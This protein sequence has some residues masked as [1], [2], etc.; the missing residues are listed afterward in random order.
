MKFKQQQSK[1]ESYMSF[2]EFGAEPSKDAPVRRVEPL[3]VVPWPGWRETHTES[4]QKND[5]GPALV[6][7]RLG[8][9]CTLRLSSQTSPH[10][11]GTDRIPGQYEGGFKVWSCSWD[12][13]SWLYEDSSLCAGKVVLEIGCG[14]AVPSIVSGARSL[15]LQDFNTEVLTEAVIPNLLANFE[16][17]RMRPE[18]V[19]LLSCDWSQLVEY[20]RSNNNVTP[21][22]VLGTDVTFTVAACRD[23]AAV[24]STIFTTNA[25]AVAF[26]ATKKYYFGT[27][28]GVQ[29]FTSAC[30]QCLGSIILLETVWSAPD[31]SRSILRV[32][33]RGE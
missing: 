31:R 20:L 19:T 25:K 23:V 9:Q 11:A 5:D 4:S 16:S 24:L 28:G 29:E 22:V 18:S 8:P 6:A 15:I 21:E 33:K 3:G 14:H 12:L 30:Q 32:T 2:L 13:A 17:G 7:H 27:G 26:I 1:K 10:G